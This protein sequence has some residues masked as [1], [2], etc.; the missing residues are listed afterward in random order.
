[1]WLNT[2]DVSFFADMMTTS[3][4]EK[5]AIHKYRITRKCHITTCRIWLVLS[6]SVREKQNNSWSKS[7]QFLWGGWVGHLTSPVA[8]PKVVGTPPISLQQAASSCLYRVL[9]IRVSWKL[10]PENS[11]ML[12][13]HAFLGRFFC[14][15]IMNHA[16]E[17][18]LGMAIISRYMAVTLPL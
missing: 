1:M 10:S 8:T 17:D 7:I 14:S 2:G 15:I 16:L 9:Q 6:S 3:R 11:L 13:F 4:L 18:G 12:L 5:K